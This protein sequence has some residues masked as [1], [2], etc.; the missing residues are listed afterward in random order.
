MVQLPTGPPPD[1]LWSKSGD[2]VYDPT[3]SEELLLHNTY[4]YGKCGYETLTRELVE[5]FQGTPKVSLENE[6]DVDEVF[7]T[8][9]HLWRGYIGSVEPTPWIDVVKDKDPKTSLGY[10][11][12]YAYTNVEALLQEFTHED[13]AELLESYEAQL[14]GG[15]MPPSIWRPFPKVDKY[16]SK[17]VLDRKFRLVSVGSFFLLMLCKR[18]FKTALEIL[19][20]GI[21]QFYLKTGNTQFS[22]KFLGRMLGG[23]SWGID[24]TAFDK[25]STQLFTI[26]GLQLLDR[27][28]GEFT[29]R[30]VF[31]YIV[32]S[33]SQP[34]SMIISP[35]GKREI[36]MLCS[37]NPSGQFF[38]SWTNSVTHLAHNCLFSR[39][40]LG[41]SELDYLTDL[42][43]M[44][45]IMTGDDGV[46]AVGTQKEAETISRAI[47]KFVDEKFNIP[48]KLEFLVDEN[49]DK[50]PFPPGVSPVYL[51]KVLV[52][53]A[54]GSSYVVPSNLKRLIPRL[55]FVLQSDII[56]SKY[57]TLNQRCQ[58]ILNE[59]MP[60]LLHEYYH[61][62]YPK[63]VIATK[64]QDFAKRYGVIMKSPIH[65]AESYLLP[66]VAKIY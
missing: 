66:E 13:I 19:E 9:Y 37:S 11:L 45:S 62:N 36:Y 63:N 28:T 54:G 4:Q 38:T 65:Y 6:Q 39:I 40:M 57:E 30:R 55:M 7:D 22:E 14:E 48:A 8:M 27:L 1:H 56:G 47:C 49:G 53:K 35:S 15:V 12:C 20:E 23:Y 24:Y 64:I 52:T 3:E 43:T 16:S 41:E 60:T 44:K 59:V 17:K 32:L 31:N 2:V 25:N 21:R 33:I 29:P 42:G 51:N 10:P 34:M 50:V 58:G 18:Y 61:R 26:K 5:T 46:D